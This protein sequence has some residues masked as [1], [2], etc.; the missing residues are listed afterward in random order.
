[1]VVVGKTWTADDSVSRLKSNM[2]IIITGFEPTEQ[3]NKVSRLKSNITDY[4]STEHINNESR[5]KSNTVTIITDYQT[6]GMITDY[7]TNGTCQ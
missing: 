1:M 7:Q 5:L 2:E 6:N 4:Q 3:V